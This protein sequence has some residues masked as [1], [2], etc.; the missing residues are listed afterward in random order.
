ARRGI[1]ANEAIS[2]EWLPHLFLR[3]SPRRVDLV[4]H[5]PVGVAVLRLRR[6]LPPPRGGEEVLAVGLGITEELFGSHARTRTSEG[7]SG[8][9]PCFPGPPASISGREQR[10]GP[11]ARRGLR[12]EVL[13]AMRG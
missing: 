2:W 13:R 7:C 5:E 4:E 3:V 12:P 6:G 8:L 9:R 10:R 11:D 1:V